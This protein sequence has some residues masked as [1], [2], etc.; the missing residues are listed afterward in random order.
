MNTAI[1]RKTLRDAA[2]LIGI[3]TL[4]LV[5]FEVLFMRA[6][7][8]ISDD[9][10]TGMALLR[11]PVVQRF[12]K[13]VA[14]AEMLDNVT[15]TSLMTLGLGHPFLLVVHWATVLTIGSRVLAGEV[16]RGTAD[17]L[18]TL[19]VSRTAVY[20]SVTLVWLLAGIPL[21]LAPWLGVCLGQQWFP[22]WEP[23]DLSRIAILCV[24][25]FFMYLA[26]GGMTMVFSALIPHRGLAIAFVLAVL[27]LS[28]VLNF[29]Q[30][31][32]QALEAISAIGV[33]HYYRPLPIV[34]SGAWPL[35]NLVALGT[36]A[37]VTWLL[38]LVRFVRRDIP[39]A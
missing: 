18:L 7:G 21:S 25:L 8:E 9:A 32:W 28:V 17:L 12:V 39:A 19:P 10:Q 24:N 13:M 23:V 26:V 34:R 5:I 20:N 14:G 2:V 22:L 11:L 37:L 35:Q 36:L 1:V 33:L 31:F 4:V 16:E 15:A 29:L 27:L 3:G 38:G 6:M 30:T